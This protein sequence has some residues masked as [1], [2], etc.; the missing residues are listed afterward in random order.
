[1]NIGLTEQEHARILLLVLQRLTANEQ[2][3]RADEEIAKIISDKVVE[4]I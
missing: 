2:A 1:M 3:Q 4:Q